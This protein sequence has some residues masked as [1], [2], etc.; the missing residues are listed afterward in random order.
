MRSVHST[1]LKHLAFVDGF[2]LTRISMPNK[3]K[4]DRK[5]TAGLDATLSAN[6]ARTE[7]LAW[8]QPWDAMHHRDFPGLKAL[9]KIDRFRLAGTA[10]APSGGFVQI[11][12]GYVEPHELT[13]HR[14]SDPL[15]A[16]TLTPLSFADAARRPRVRLDGAAPSWRPTCFVTAPS[17]AWAALYARDAQ[18]AAG[19]LST[20]SGAVRWVAPVELPPEALV[21]LHPFDDGRVVLAAYL[22]SRRESVLVRFFA[23]GTVA[24]QHTLATITPAVPVSFD[25]ALHQPDESV[26]ARTP[27]DGGISRTTGLADH[28]AA[29]LF[30]HGDAGYALVWHGESVIDLS[31]AEAISRKFADDD[32]PV[33]RF[34]REHLARAN[35]LGNPAGILFELMSFDPNPARRDFSFSFDATSGNGSLRGVLAAGM[36]TAITD[37]DALRNLHGWHWSVGGGLSPSVAQGR[38]DDA[39]VDAAFGALEAARVPL[40]E[41]LKCLGDAYSF[42]HT[43]PAPQRVPFTLDGARRFLAGMTWALTHRGAEGV[44]AA[45]RE[46]APGLTVDD[47]VAAMKSLPHERG[48]RVDYHA[49]DLLTVVSAQVFR[50]ELTRVVAALCRLPDAWRNGVASRLEHAVK[51]VKSE[52]P[53]PD[54]FATMVAL[55]SAARGEIDF[56]VR[57]ALG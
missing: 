14:W 38:W 41:C 49:L 46:L 18:L 47:V 24:G 15:S 16:P 37:D 4:T 50:H 1:D 5:V 57:R 27:L 21:T 17:G 42:S 34:F 40:L 45:S 32:A 51:W 35:A 56:Y 31:T 48:P 7:L 25:H 2:G 9:S 43:S 33:R 23:D 36:L 8:R 54:V 13:L 26:V 52:T 29:R 22:P 3:V 6:A 10:L 39:E 19:D 30:G 11:T 44:R 28:G 20:P 53:E 55:E 12:S